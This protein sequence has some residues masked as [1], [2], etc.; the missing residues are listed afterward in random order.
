VVGVEGLEP[1]TLG[2]EIRCSIQLSYTPTQTITIIQ[3][4]NFAKLGEFKPALPCSLS[5]LAIFNIS[6][7]FPKPPRFISHTQAPP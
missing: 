7:I 4:D 1:P 2:L 3:Y 5:P 6:N